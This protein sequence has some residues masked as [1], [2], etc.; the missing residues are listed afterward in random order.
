M[1][2][3]GLLV[4]VGHQV[5]Q[6]IDALR[7][8][9][10]DAEA[11][12]AGWADSNEALGH[13]A[14][15][16]VLLKNAEATADAVR[17]A[18]DQLAKQSA[19]R[20]FDFIHVHFSCHGTPDGRLILSNTIRGQHET[21]TL[22]LGEITQ[23]LA[24]VRA[25][26]AVLTFDSC[27]AGTVV[28]MEDSP[29]AAAFEALLTALANETRAVAWAAG[30]MERAWESTRLTH[31]YLSCGLITGLRESVALGRERISIASWLEGAL[32]FTVTQARTAG[33]I[34]NPRAR[35]D[36]SATADVLVPRDGP[37]QQRFRAEGGIRSAGP[38]PG[39]LRQYGF[40]DN[41]IAAMEARLEPG[42]ELNDLQCQSIAPGGVLCGRSVVVR[43]PT[44]AGKSVVGELA[45][46]SRILH[47]RKA[48]VLLPTRALVHEQAARFARHYGCL[49]RRL[50]RSAGDAADQDGLLFGQHFDAAF[51]TYEKF[52]ALV[53][54]RP[55]ILAAVGTVVLDEVQM[56]SDASRGPTVELILTRLLQHGRKTR[57]ELQVV[58]LCANV[59]DLNHLHEWL[60]AEPLGDGTRP[61]P[62][63][64]AVVAP[65]GKLLRRSGD[66]FEPLEEHLDMDVNLTN[67]PSRYREH[68]I[69]ARLARALVRRE[70][71]DGRQVL[72]F[73]GTKFAARRLAEDLAE[74]L[75]L[76][77]AENTLNA[78]R[79]QAPTDHDR[80][81]AQAQLY[82]HLGGGIGFHIA[83]LDRTERE[84]V[85]AG[86]HAAE[87]RVLVATTTLAMGVNTPANTVVVVDTELPSGPAGAMEPVDVTTYRN[88]A[89]RAGRLGFA[90]AGEAYLLAESDTSAG[91]LW[92]RYLASPGERLGSAL[93]R[94]ADGDLLLALAAQGG[95][96]TVTDLI[97][98]IQQTY[99][100]YLNRSRG[101]WWVQRRV[102]LRQ[103]AEELIRE[104]Y[105]VAT[106]EPHYALST[107]GRVCAVFGL[108]FASSRRLLDVIDR[109]MTAGEQID[110]GTLMALAQLTVELDETYIHMAR[111]E[112]FDWLGARDAWLD[113]KPTLKDAFRS[114]ANDREA[115]VRLKRFAGLRL[116]IRGEPVERIEALY[117]MRRDFPTF[118]N[119]RAVADRTID[120]IS[121]IAGLVGAR[122]RDRRREL[123]D[124]ASSLRG[125]LGFGG[126]RAAT[127]LRLA[128]PAL[129]RHQANELVRCGIHGE[130]QLLLALEG[131]NAAVLGILTSPVAHDVRQ[132]L[133]A[134]RQDGA[135]S[136]RQRDQHVLDLFGQ[137]DEF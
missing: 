84:A 127:T 3:A 94:M 133:Q 67:L 35:V 76:H 39:D 57:Q 105:L 45:V 78:L 14:D 64:E 108:R 20:A 61:V 125:R 26:L 50:V 34:Q 106:S 122:Q 112:E 110:E 98:T 82:R 114:S 104:Q 36:L 58:A 73:C 72:V 97:S 86:F 80:S 90:A 48:V 22:P 101:E 130:E 68:A 59:M 23:R 4:G 85:E 111:N 124:F 79:R 99:L 107:I 66:R 29:N 12:W 21:T 54:A 62:L 9:A 13:S 132:R 17:A 65:S 63:N 131:E 109:M 87:V 51:L 71:D 46:L 89:G 137:K 8:A 52:A 33:L 2:T 121:A 30:P 18:I 115:G 41:L 117:D 10:R 42:G 93:D 118:G 55:S 134:R 81:R 123:R 19:E 38:S 27:F 11:L 95:E 74:D 129:S 92:Q 75:Q 5:D 47:D 113:A 88:M 120:V 103:V 77:A 24:T 128:E 16:I 40:P 7:F 60:G 56:I 49:G 32:N 102:L 6:R 119:L 100:G 116:W 70:V 135:S 15:S 37:R 25:S 69:R 96:T 126:P 91:T 31:G 44:S 136:T 43:A 28:G 1:L 83:D 53:V